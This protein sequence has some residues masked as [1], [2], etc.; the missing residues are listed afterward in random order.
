MGKGGVVEHNKVETEKE[1]RLVVRERMA[2][3]MAV[4]DQRVMSSAAEFVEWWNS[5][6]HSTSNK[7]S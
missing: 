5:L 6:D 1:T 3:C 2:A 4:P 7:P